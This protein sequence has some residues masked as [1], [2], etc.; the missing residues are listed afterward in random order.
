MTNSHDPMPSD[1]TD[2]LGEQILTALPLRA[3]RWRTFFVVLGFLGLLVFD[4]AINFNTVGSSFSDELGQMVNP[5]IACAFSL[6]SEAWPAT[7]PWMAC[8]TPCRWL[9][10]GRCRGRSMTIWTL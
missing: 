7:M 5:L 10:I 4:A 6:S 9:V 8:S 2:A 1:Q 3:L